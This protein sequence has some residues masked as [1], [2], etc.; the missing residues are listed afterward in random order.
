MKPAV[1]FL[2]FFDTEAVDINIKMLFLRREVQPPNLH[3]V[4]L[5][6]SSPIFYMASSDFSL[7]ASCSA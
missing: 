7:I 6:K 1:E 5:S 2:L 4:S 3:S